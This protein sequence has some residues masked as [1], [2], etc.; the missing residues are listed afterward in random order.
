MSEEETK[1]VEERIVTPG[2]VP[3]VFGE[4]RKGVGVGPLAPDNQQPPSGSNFAPASPPPKEAD[5]KD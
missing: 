4:G 5:A 1:R 2:R 3:E